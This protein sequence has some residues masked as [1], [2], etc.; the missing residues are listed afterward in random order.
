MVEVKAEG[1]VED[2]MKVQEEEG[3]KKKEEVEEEE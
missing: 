3:G 2:E 1:M